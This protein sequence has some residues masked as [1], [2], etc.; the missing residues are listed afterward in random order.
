ML[1]TTG[2]N[3]TTQAGVIP[4]STPPPTKTLSFAATHTQSTENTTST[5]IPVQTQAMQDAL[6]EASCEEQSDW[7]EYTIQRGDNLTKI[8]DKTRSTV[9]ELIA[10]NCMED[11]NRI[12]VGQTIYVP[13]AP[14]E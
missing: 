12:R 2:C 5:E 10:A 4:S 9:D 6:D 1:A 8:A 11:P 7:E 13:N 3:L 14:E